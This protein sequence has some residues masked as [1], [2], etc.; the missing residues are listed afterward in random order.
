MEADNELMDEITNKKGYT[1]GHCIPNKSNF[2]FLMRKLSHKYYLHRNLLYTNPNFDK[3]APPPSQPD[4][5][6]EQIA[7]FF[8]SKK[9]DT[10]RNTSNTQ[11]YSVTKHS[12]HS[13]RKKN[14]TYD[15]EN[16]PKTRISANTTG[17]NMKNTFLHSLIKGK[18]ISNEIKREGLNSEK[19]F[20]KHL[21]PNSRFSTENNQTGRNNS[22]RK[23]PDPHIHFAGIRKAK[24]EIERSK[25][26]SGR[27]NKSITRSLF[28]ESQ[29][30]ISFIGHKGNIQARNKVPVF[31]PSIDKLLEKSSNSRNMNLFPKYMHNRGNTGT[32]KLEFRA[33]SKPDLS[34]TMDDPR[35][36][37]KQAIMRVQGELEV[38][39]YDLDKIYRFDGFN[40][41]RPRFH[42]SYL[43]QEVNKNTL[44]SAL[45]KKQGINMDVITNLSSKEL[46]E[47][48]NSDVTF[49][50]L[51]KTWRKW[52]H[53]PG[54][55][56]ALL[57]IIQNSPEKFSP[58]GNNAKEIYAHK[59]LN[60]TS[61]LSGD[62]LTMEGRNIHSRNK[63]GS[64]PDLYK[65]KQLKRIV[66]DK[67]RIQ[68]RNE[69]Q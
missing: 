8:A 43:G 32:T 53:T 26:V 59:R 64:S 54:D 21:S 66:H 15:N 40:Q 23:T 49:K 10:S 19:E 67:I 17:R 2:P 7:S 34:M 60:R 36:E 1:P 35:R 42:S 57:R 24:H 45:I 33:I 9:T 55:R 65:N 11:F 22:R 18:N 6:Q 61:R 56:R 13:E 31:L 39:D 48:F 58:R 3:M 47:R 69:Y 14:L 4:L 46:A 29:K 28:Q 62:L 30:N 41:K 12:P 20:S 63:S 16:S 50:R 44:L 5:V 25:S 68:K 51:T 27:R 37:M 38:S 52:N